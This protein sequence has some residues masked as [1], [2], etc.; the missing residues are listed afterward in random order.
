MADTPLRILIAD[1]EPLARDRLA[2]LCAHWP[3][4]VIVGVAEDGPATLAQVAALAP[5]LILLD[6]AMPGLNG[7]EVA[8][9]IELLAVRPA[10]L[11]CTAH[12]R[13][14][15]AAF[16]V[17]A[18][19]YLLK[20]VSVERLGRA[21][22]RARSARTATPS[23]PSDPR[24]AVG[25]DEFWVP[26]RNEMIRIAAADIDR[27]DAERDYMRLHVGPRSYLLHETI[28]ALERR[29]DPA[30]FLRVHRSTIL[31]RD[32]IDSLRHDGLGGWYADLID[33][34]SV[35]IGRTYLPAARALIGR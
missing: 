13:F 20:P 1:D 26:V 25:S 16:D 28:G 32:R 8:A 27:I 24:G 2:A 31:R 23:A 15:V 10:I 7:L 14:A 4:L 29:L 6:I 11:F 30:R 33:G 18:V 19:D 35:R 12:D 5:D 21:I 9:A 22:P 34:N 17:A 3:D